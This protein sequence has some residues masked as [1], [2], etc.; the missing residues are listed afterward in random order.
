VKR[1][2]ESY[3]F[4]E[5]APGCKQRQAFAHKDDPDWMDTDCSPAS[6]LTAAGQLERADKVVPTTVA[7]DAE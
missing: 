5:V 4:L 2:N 6:P 3:L 7:I 1:Q